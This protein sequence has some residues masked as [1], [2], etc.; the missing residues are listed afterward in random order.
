[1]S[2]KSGTFY[3]IICDHDGCEHRPSYDDAEGAVLASAQEAEDSSSDVDWLAVD[4]KHYCPEHRDAY[5]CRHCGEAFAEPVPVDGDGI[6]VCLDCRATLD[7]F[8]TDGEP[9][10]EAQVATFLAV[11]DGVT[12][13]VHGDEELTDEDREALGIV[14]QAAAQQ[15]AGGQA[16]AE[17]ISAFRE[18]AGLP[19]VG[20]EMTR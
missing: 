2:V 5:E 9:S 1:M 8:D 14:L 12:A 19:A 18:R 7:E 16:Q 13:L 15:Y 10:P 6:P 4:G 20:E 3:W 11:A 17:R